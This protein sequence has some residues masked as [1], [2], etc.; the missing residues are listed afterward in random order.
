MANEVFSWSNGGA[1][2][3]RDHIKNMKKNMRKVPIIQTKSDIYHNKEE[4]EAENI[5]KN[6][7]NQKEQRAVES[8]V[9]TRKQNV[10]W[11]EN[12]VIRL[13][14]KIKDLLKNYK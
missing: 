1:Y 14:Q 11:N 13:W 5:L 4:I 10:D 2:L 7:I 12:I 8:I 3:S 6:A 9:Q